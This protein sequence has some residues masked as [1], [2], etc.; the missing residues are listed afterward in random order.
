MPPGRGFPGGSTGARYAHPAACGP[1]A[2]R[3]GPST[4]WD[5]VDD[6]TNY[7]TSGRIVHSDFERG[8]VV[9]EDIMRQGVLFR[10]LPGRPVVLEFDQTH[11]RFNGRPIFLNA[12]DERLGLTDRPAR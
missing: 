10:T 4:G 5:P 7:A 2:G 12:C 3:A 1:T 8:L 6:E 9:T 11:A